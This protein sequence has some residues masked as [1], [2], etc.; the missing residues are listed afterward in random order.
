MSL[1]SLVALSFL[2]QIPLA[3]RKS[4]L[5]KYS[6]ADS[7]L[8]RIRGGTGE[9]KEEDEVFRLIRTGIDLK[10]AEREVALVKRMGGWIEALGSPSYPPWLG[11][12]PDP[13]L[14]LFGQG[15]R[16]PFESL[17]IGMVGTRHPSAYGLRVARML[18]EDL[19]RQ[20][21]VLVSGMARGI[22]AAAHQSA[23]KAKAFTVAAVAHGLDQT[24]PPEHAQLRKEIQSHG[25]CITEFPLGSAP[26]PFRFPLRNRL[27]SGLSRGVLVV[28]AGEKSGARHTVRHACD[29]GRDV[30]AVPGP[31]DSPR[32]IFPNQLIS[33]GAKLVATSEDIMSE[34]MS[35][36]KGAAVQ[37]G[38]DPRLENLPREEMEFLKSI[39]L[40]IPLSVDDLASR[41]QKPISKVLALLTELELKGCVQR[42]SQARFVRTVVCGE[43][44]TG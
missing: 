17:Y 8:K 39:D 15:D 42:N 33:E 34:F 36:E 12:I 30:F 43:D 37:K 18:G 2:D 14:V 24:Y 23:I 32:S 16:L 29:Q 25:A 21:V 20:G 7:L 10:R 41:Q 9:S 1:L 22:D 4:L 19:A 27:I 44:D 35:V 6:G 5:E 31:V 13:P 38:A 40:D 28:E 26:V 11:Q 3:L